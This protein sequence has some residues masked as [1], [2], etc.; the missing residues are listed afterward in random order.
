MHSINP[1]LWTSFV[2]CLR[3]TMWPLYLVKIQPAGQSFLV[4]LFKSFTVSFCNKIS[5]FIFLENLF[6][7]W[8]SS[9]LDFR[10]CWVLNIFFSTT[11]TCFKEFIYR[12][13]FAFSPF[14]EICPF[15]L[16]DTYN[17]LLIFSINRS[18]TFILKI[19]IF[20]QARKKS[21]CGFSIIIGMTSHNN[22]YFYL[23]YFTK[24]PALL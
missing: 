3:I 24:Q 2:I 8:S 20:C 4:I 15:K 21:I 9:W 17:R 19:F 16:V 14:F 7:C 18:Y 1:G 11:Q 10:K 5:R 23:L 22:I 13:L 6:P 12:I